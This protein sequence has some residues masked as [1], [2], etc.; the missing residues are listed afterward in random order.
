MLVRR[1]A[2][3]IRETRP[4]AALAALIVI[5]AMLALVVRLYQLQILRGNDYVAQSVQNFRKSLFVPAD[6]G[7]LLD[8]N[9]KTLVDNRPSFDVYMTPAYCKPGKAPGEKEE[10]W[11]QLAADLRMTREDVRQMR[12]AHQTPREEDRLEP[13]RQTARR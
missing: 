2:D 7:S 11:T 3:E 6:R 12:L 8:R 1:D 4:R 9:G 13:R 5:C 10:V